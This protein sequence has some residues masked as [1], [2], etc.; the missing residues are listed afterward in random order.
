MCQNN[1]F[2]YFFDGYAYKIHGIILRWSCNLDIKVDEP[3]WQA[4]RRGTLVKFS[5][6]VKIF[7]FSIACS[8]NYLQ[9]LKYKIIKY[10]S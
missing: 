2:I 1:N 4:C 8:P 10:K 3:I 5:Q 9:F 6:L 7:F